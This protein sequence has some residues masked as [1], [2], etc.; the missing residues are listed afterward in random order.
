MRIRENRQYI[1][2]SLVTLMTLSIDHSQLANEL[3]RKI[4]AAYCYIFANKLT[5]G[6]I[7]LPR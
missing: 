4:D 3:G 1:N 2:T 5:D 6:Y 7:D